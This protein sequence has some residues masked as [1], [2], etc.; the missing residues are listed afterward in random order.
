MHFLQDRRGFRVCKKPFTKMSIE[1]LNLVNMVEILVG[2]HDIYRQQINAI[3]VQT[4]L[5]HENDEKNSKIAL[6]QAQ[7]AMESG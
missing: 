5:V 4:R 3:V 7:S 2:V 1:P 6:L